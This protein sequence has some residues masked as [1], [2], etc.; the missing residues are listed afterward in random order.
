MLRLQT[1]CSTCWVLG[2]CAFG[3]LV[4]DL[5]WQA[6]AGRSEYYGR[7]SEQQIMDRTEPLC[8]FTTPDSGRLAMK[9]A[10]VTSPRPGRKNQR[11]WAVD[12]YASGGEY[13]A[14]FMWNADTGDLWQVSC[15]IRQSQSG[16][17]EVMD[18]RQAIRESWRWLAKLDFAGRSAR[19]RVDPDSY[20]EGDTWS[21]CWRGT[22]IAVW[23][24]IGSRS[25][26]LRIARSQEVGSPT[27]A[28]FDR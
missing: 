8:R 14:G 9:T 27:A 20:I 7:F 1:V 11:H 13:V 3:V 5:F 19:W 24:K 6:S 17:F 12:C 15:P 18:R 26:D 16:L 25:G 22:G 2:T 23:L 21:V 10:R 28:P 4:A